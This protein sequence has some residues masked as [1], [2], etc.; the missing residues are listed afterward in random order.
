MAAKTKHPSAQAPAPT[1]HRGTHAP[2]DAVIAELCN[3]GFSKGA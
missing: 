3:D 1:P 2:R